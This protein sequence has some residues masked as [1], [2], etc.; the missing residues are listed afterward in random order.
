MVTKTQA[1]KN[2]L[3]ANTHPELAE[4]YAFEMECQ[5]IVSQAGGERAE[6]EFKGRG[7]NAYTDGTTIWKPIRIPWNA[8]ED[9][10]FK[11]SAMEYDLAKY[12]EGVG[13]TGWNWVNRCSCWVAF[14]FDG[15]VGHSDQHQRKL[16]PTELEDVR[17]AVENIPWVTIRRSTS[18]SGLHLYVDTNN[19]P[20]DNHTEHAAL[21]RYVLGLMSARAGFDF[22]SKVDTCGGNMWVWHKKMRGTNGLQL[23]KVAE[24]SLINIDSSW[25]SHVPIIK[26]RGGKA[27]HSQVSSDKMA[28]FDELASQ[29]PHTPLDDAHKEL[30][31]YLEGAKIRWWWDQDRHMLVTHTFGLQMAHKELGLKGVFLTM[32]TGTEKE[33]DHNCFLFPMPR[34]SWTVRR[35]SPGC[36]EHKSW[37][38]DGQGWTKCFLNREPDL[39]TVARNEG[40][41]EHK[42]GGFVFPDL[43]TA[44]RALNQFGISIDTA[45]FGPVELLA[46][47]PVHVFQHKDGRVVIEVPRDKSRDVAKDYPG[48]ILERDKITKILN[49]RLPSERETEVGT[50]QDELIRHIITSGRQDAGW[51]LNVEGSWVHEPLTHI[52]IAMRAK[53]YSTTEVTEFIGAAI[54]KPWTLVCKPFQPEYPGGGKQWNLGAV[55]YAFPPSNTEAPVYTHWRQ[56]LDHWGKELDGPL[57][58]H[59][60]AVANGIKTGGEYLFLWIASMFQAPYEPLPYLFLWGKQNI[61]KSLFHEAMSLLIGG[62]TGSGGVVQAESALTN[63]N[64]F[65]GELEQAIL[66][67]VEEVDLKKNKSASNRIKDW[68]TSKTLQIHRKKE[69]PYPQPNTTHWVQM[70]NS[71]EFCPIFPGDTRITV[72]HVPVLPKSVEIPK[73]MLLNLLAK[74]G[75]DFLNALL[76]VDIPASGERLNIPVIATDDKKEIEISNEDAFEKFIREHC[77]QV[78]GHYVLFDDLF[79]EFKLSLSDEESRNW[80]KIAFGRQLVGNFPKARLAVEGSPLAIGNISLDVDAKPEKFKYVIQGAFLKKEETRESVIEITGG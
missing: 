19:T 45:D 26:A 33:N 68:V 53:G 70:T 62:G 22:Q 25:K 46:G 79:R 75:P 8:A 66:C 64:G 29:M 2:F 48:W 24:E 51:V 36:K 20:T 23:L 59:P 3:V 61:G 55:Q 27:K 77:V 11:D 47:K 18:G 13:M 10:K 63:P 72:I 73:A 69:T 6:P 65:N 7:H 14:D 76:A 12:A 49:S 44:N 57:S 28:T 78:P 40:A 4:M 58:Q 52:N 17:K 80:S 15:I 60:W 54:H 21:G 50:S 9:P 41:A 32:S 35:F 1:I 30:I 42:K 5:V 71:P 16:S 31:K 56:V 38:Q 67:F 43:H 37:D 34:G 74:E 39:N